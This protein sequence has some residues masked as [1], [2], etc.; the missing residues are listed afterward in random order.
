MEKLI[1]TVATTGGLTTRDKTPY[2]PLTPKEIADEV[3]ASWKAGAAV[4]H[5]H[6]RDKQGR[7]SLDYDTYVETVG[8]IKER[9][10][11]VINL[12]T[13]GGIDAPDDVRIRPTD[14]KPEL[15]SFDAGSVNMGPG[16]FVNSMPFLEKLA[17]ACQENGVKPEVEVFEAGMINNALM[18]AQKG[19]IAQPMHFQFVLGVPGAMPG[20]PRNL[21]HLVD[22]LPP[23]STW[24]VIGV[25]KCHLPLATMAIH[26]GGH[27]RVG[28]ED[29]VYLKKGVL[30]KSNAEFVERIVKLAEEF[31]RPVA[32]PAEARAI[33]GLGS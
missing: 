10:D 32:T 22:S 18:F 2:L 23:G 3:V 24:S 16:V 4:A 5:I 12:T 15:A 26:M 33:L 28:M 17:K 19:L 31:E 1:I 6:V 11:I 30:A 13:S 14:L 9:C 8:L 25:G 7:G 21:V 27:V 29:N 20:T